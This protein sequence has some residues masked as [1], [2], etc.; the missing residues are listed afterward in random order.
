MKGKV[1]IFTRLCVYTK[2][3]QIWLFHVVRDVKIYDDDGRGKRSLQNITWLYF[4]SFA[5]IQFCSPPTTWAK[6][7]KNKLVRAVLE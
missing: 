3:S 6:Y 2:R 7:P 1:E 4:K 5:I